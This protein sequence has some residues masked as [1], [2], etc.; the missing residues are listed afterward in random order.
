MSSARITLADKVRIRSSNATEA[1]GIAG[2]TGIVYGSTTPSVTGVRVVGNP[3]ED[4]AISVTLDGRNDQLWFADDL[5]EFVDHQTGTTVSI[6]G[7]RL[8][9]DE[10]GEWHEV[11]SQ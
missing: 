1:L 3:I 4:Y 7:R 11:K 10:N 9:R 8:I 6:A 5:L 2:Q